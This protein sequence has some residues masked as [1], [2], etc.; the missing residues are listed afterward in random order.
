MTQQK[1][2]FIIIATQNQRENKRM[3]GYFE[4]SSGFVKLCILV[5]IV[6]TCALIGICVST[7]YLQLI[8]AADGIGNTQAL[9]FIQNSCLFILSPLMIQ[10]FLW[11]DPIRE[12]LHFKKPTLLVLFIGTLAI[13]SI[14]PFIDMLATWNKGVHLPD[15]MH[16]IELWMVQSENAAEAITKQ[17]LSINTWN[18]FAANI[19]IVALMAGI[20]EELMF[21]GVLQKLFIGWTKNTHAGILI[22]AFIFSAIHLQ[23]FGFFPRFALGALLGYMFAWS[24]SIWVP[25]IAHSLNNA[26]VIILSSSFVNQNNATL[27]E[28]KD[29]HIPIWTGVLSLTFVCIL[30]FTLKKTQANKVKQ[31]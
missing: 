19:V 9:L 28:L 13:I 7:V 8:K 3:K 14:S 17:L 4:N 1:V 16:A 24:G 26:I 20:G 25:I 15:S 30:M 18:G 5:L 12:A 22:A 10:H 2:F 11:K 31:I 21:R 29:T 27:G 23:F 6:S